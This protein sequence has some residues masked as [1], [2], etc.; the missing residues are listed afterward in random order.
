MNE[1]SVLNTQSIASTHKRAATVLGKHQND[2]RNNHCATPK[3]LSQ[4]PMEHNYARFLDLEL[5]ARLKYK[6]C[7]TRSIEYESDMITKETPKSFLGESMFLQQNP[8]TM[9]VSRAQMGKKYSTV[10]RSI[11]SQMGYS[12]TQTRA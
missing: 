8:I 1:Y 4:H 6:Q 3:Q 9:S 7:M 5:N 11:S 10:T 2:A 12:E